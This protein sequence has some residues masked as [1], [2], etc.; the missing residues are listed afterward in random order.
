MADHLSPDTL[1][2]LLSELG[3]FTQCNIP[4]VEKIRA[5]HEIPVTPP[6][7]PDFNL[8]DSALHSVYVYRAEF[9]DA[10]NSLTSGSIITDPLDIV[11]SYVGKI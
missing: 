7:M 9:E 4:T 1:E 11:Y 6:V 8:T 10:F 5:G 2:G 3:D